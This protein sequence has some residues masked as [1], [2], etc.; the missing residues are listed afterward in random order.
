VLKRYAATS[1]SY[2]QAKLAPFASI[3]AG[4]QLRARGTKNADG[5]DLVATEIVSGTF[6]NLSGKIDSIDSTVSTISLKDLATKKQLTVHITNGA[7]MRQLPDQIAQVLGA[8]L[9]ATANGSAAPT[10]PPANTQNQSGAQRPSYGG[11]NGPRD[12][13]Q[14]LNRAPQIHLA[15]LKKGDV[16]MLVA[17]DDGTQLTAITLLSGVEPLLEAPAAS[18]DLLSNWSVGSG[19]SEAAAGAQ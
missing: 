6:L 16:V 12:P 1:I 2:D 7:Q 5:T 14:I 17:T 15:D 10:N 19:G 18:K 11:G 4:D 8:R 9:K 13:Q 3:H